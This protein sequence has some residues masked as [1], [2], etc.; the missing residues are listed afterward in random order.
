MR[1]VQESTETAYERKIKTSALSTARLKIFVED[2][3]S[4]MSDLPRWES[5][6]RSS[7][8]TRLEVSAA[9]SN[10][11]IHFTTYNE[12]SLLIKQNKI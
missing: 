4:E 3:K 12:L 2:S 6:W 7:K 11:H 5:T 1:K 9:D 10:V 8:G